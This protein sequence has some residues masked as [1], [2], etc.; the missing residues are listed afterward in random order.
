MIHIGHHFSH[1]VDLMEPI[2]QVATF[3][4]LVCTVIGG[5]S[6]KM[7][8]FIMTMIS[9]VIAMA[10]QDENGN[11]DSRRAQMLTTVP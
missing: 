9:L 7:W 11:L 6:Q 8:D 10:G 3:M 5:L 4:A 1:P 2:A